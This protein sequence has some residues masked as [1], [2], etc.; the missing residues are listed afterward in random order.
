MAQIIKIKDGIVYV[1][2]PTGQ[3]I[4]V[5]RTSI[6]SEPQVGASVNVYGTGDNVIITQ[7][8]TSAVVNNVNQQLQN[9][10]SQSLIIPPYSRPVNKIAYALLA[11]FVGGFGIHKFYAGKT[12]MGILYLVFFWTFIPAIVAFIEA[13]IA[14][15]KPADQYGNIYI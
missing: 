2:M 15:T 5:K 14:L 7:T 6:D 3:I 13:I 8:L 12:G 4:E 1:G 11:L 9:I 10:N